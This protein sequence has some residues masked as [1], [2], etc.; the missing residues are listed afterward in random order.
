V[1]RRPSVACCSRERKFWGGFSSVA[2][3][4]SMYSR[5]V[6]QANAYARGRMAAKH[7]ILPLPAAVLILDCWTPRA[8]PFYPPAGINPEFP[9]NPRLGV[10]A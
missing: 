7:H 4:Q 5:Y 1:R 2:M 8:G 6:R 10:F 3:V 9:P